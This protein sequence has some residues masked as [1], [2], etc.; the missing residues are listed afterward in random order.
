MSA[1]KSGNDHRLYKIRGKVTNAKRNK[2]KGSG[3]K[4]PWKNTK[5]ILWL[6]FPEWRFANAEEVD[7]LRR[8]AQRKLS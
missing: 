1:H 5:V 8:I 6:G 2:G 3:E 7:R 4:V